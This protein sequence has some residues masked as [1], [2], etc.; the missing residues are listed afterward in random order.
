MAKCKLIINKMSG[1]T[2]NACENNEFRKL[3]L[4]NY[5]IVDTAYI[6]NSNAKDLDMKNEVIGYDALA[7]CGGDG[8]LNS[9]INAIENKQIELVYLPTGTLN[10][11]AKSLQLVKELSADN[12]HIRR[13]D[14]GKVGQTMFAY[15]LAGGIFTPIG[16]RTDI[17]R[18]KKYKIGAYFARILEEYKIHHIKAK[19]EI[20]DEVFEDTYSLIMVINASRCFGFGFN[21]RFVHN[22]GKG[23]LL[24]IKA[25]KTKGLLAKIKIFFPLFR[26]FFL[27]LKKEIR[28][29]NLVFIDFEKA[30]LT[31]DG[32]YDFTVDGEH[33]K[34]TGTNQIE[35]LRQKLK[36]VVF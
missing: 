7:V 3:L 9:A 11:T 15:V 1:N 35:I 2:K 31:I 34:L 29:K 6:D 21:K 18:K 10:E 5:E 19:I 36:L 22:D 30:T 32:E 23:Q 12:R 24:L 4:K 16:Y 27:H 14:M 20:G 26:T 8:T 33:I 28:S 17:K 25:P 13:V